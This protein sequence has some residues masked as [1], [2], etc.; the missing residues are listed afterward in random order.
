MDATQI[1]IIAGAVTSFLGLLG[2]VAIMVNT[3]FREGRIRRWALEDKVELEA[4]TRHTLQ[5]TAQSLSLQFEEVRE[6]VKEEV[7]KLAEKGE[8]RGAT[9][10]K[11]IDENTEVSREAFKEANNVNEKLRDLGVERDA[12]L[13]KQVIVANVEPIAVIESQKTA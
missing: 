10:V 11:K 3:N 12:V 9:I 4:T 7:Q 5:D 8:E 2:T 13:P 1:T 6:M